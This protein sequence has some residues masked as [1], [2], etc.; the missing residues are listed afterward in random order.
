[1]KKLN[2]EEILNVLKDELTKEQYQ[3]FE[4]LKETEG[5][6][7]ALANLPDPLNFCEEKYHTY[8][9]PNQNI[10]KL[11]EQFGLT[12][13]TLA[14]FLNVTQKEY[15]RLEKDGYN[16]STRNLLRIASFYNIS[17]DWILGFSKKQTPLSENSFG[18]FDLGNV[19]RIL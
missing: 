6:E 1:M 7:K 19:E 4:F 8:A 3:I 12:Q 17:C 9:V 2:T 15:W 10:K 13:T 14:N 5:I 16:I 11:R 18:L